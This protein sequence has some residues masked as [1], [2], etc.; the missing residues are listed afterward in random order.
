MTDDM[1]T[2]AFLDGLTN[3]DIENMERAWSL[4]ITCIPE[5]LVTEIDRDTLVEKYSRRVFYEQD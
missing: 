1:K 3:E 5:N 2:Q 4:G